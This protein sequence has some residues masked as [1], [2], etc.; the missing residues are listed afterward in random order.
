MVWSEEAFPDLSVAYSYRGTE[1]DYAHEYVG[2][3]QLISKKEQWVKV[4]HIVPL[5][6]AQDSTHTL[7]LYPMSK[8][9]ENIYLDDIRYEIITLKE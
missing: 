7:I 4:E 3:G 8:G 9:E 6:V 5:T 2:I 1:Q